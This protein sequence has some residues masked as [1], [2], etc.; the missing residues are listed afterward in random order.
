MHAT[1]EQM[2]EVM[3][4]HKGEYS[5]VDPEGSTPFFIEEGYND[6]EDWWN[7]I[8]NLNH[9][10]LV[11]ARLRGFGI[12]QEYMGIVVSIL[13]ME[14]AGFSYWRMFT[15]SA[16]TRCDAAWAAYQAWKEQAK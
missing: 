1:N 12:E 7:P 11:A 2:A 6:S 3:G 13:R 14:E 4:W 8:A 15:A 16:Q 9:V 5:W 10:A